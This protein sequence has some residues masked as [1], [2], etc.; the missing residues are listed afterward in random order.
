MGV[1]DVERAGSSEVR[2]HQTIR[3]RRSALS[4]QAFEVLG[5]P[6]IIAARAFTDLSDFYS[7][8]STTWAPCSILQS[9]VRL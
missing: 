3:Q 6:A 9:P 2:T 7:K 1:V 4:L 8:G 5:F